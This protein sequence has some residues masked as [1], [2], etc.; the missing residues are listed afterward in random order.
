MNP[1]VALGL[2][3][4]G[5]SHP[6]REDFVAAAGAE[7]HLACLF[8]RNHRLSLPLFEKVSTTGG[9]NGSE[10]TALLYRLFW[11]ASQNLDFSIQLPGKTHIGEFYSPFY[12]EIYQSLDQGLNLLHCPALLD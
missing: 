9:G 3:H 5:V 10:V 6:L 12:W 7:N 8:D 2:D 1:S 11:E 4:N